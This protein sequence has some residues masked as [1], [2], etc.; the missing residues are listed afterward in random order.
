MR[1]SRDAHAGHAER[2]PGGNGSIGH[3]PPR[4]APACH[5]PSHCAGPAGTEAIAEHQDAKHLACPPRPAA[6]TTSIRAPYT[7]LHGPNFAAYRVF[8]RDAPRM[9]PSRRAAISMLSP[10]E[11]GGAMTRRLA[12]PGRHGLQ[13]FLF[14]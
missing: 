5:R 8:T 10:Q 11:S 3:G 1:G 12:L 9:Q 4:W 13:P 2:P 14:T 7:I 6:P